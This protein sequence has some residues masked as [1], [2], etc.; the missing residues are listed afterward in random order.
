MLAVCEH[1]DLPMRCCPC[2]ST[3]SCWLVSIAVRMLVLPQCFVNAPPPACVLRGG[4]H[5]AMVIADYDACYY[6]ACLPLQ[7]RTVNNSTL[8]ADAANKEEISVRIAQIRKELSETDSVY[9]TEKLSQRI[10]KLAGGVAVIK[11]RSHPLI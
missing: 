6:D 5:L 9:D 4:L 11:V 7:I 1:V 10:A 2:T 3:Y 8:I